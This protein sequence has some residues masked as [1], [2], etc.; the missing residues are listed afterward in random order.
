TRFNAGTFFN[1]R[2]EHFTDAA[3]AGTPEGI[4]ATNGEGFFHAFRH[5][6]FSNNYQWRTSALMGFVDPLADLLHAGGDFWDEH[7]VGTGSH[8]RMQGNPANVAAH[9][10]GHH[11]AVVRVASGAQTVNGFYG[12]LVS[13]IETERVIGGVQVI[14][15]GLGNANNWQA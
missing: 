6:A 13:G 14:I 7:R 15:D 10:L 3:Q 1:D 5:K 12:D 8:A 11:A 9:Y 2:G 4:N